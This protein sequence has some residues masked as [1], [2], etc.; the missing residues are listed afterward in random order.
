MAGRPVKE[1]P[2]DDSRATYASKIQKKDAL[3][4]WTPPA[5]EISC[6]IRALDPSPGAYTLL[7]GEKLKLFS[8]TV[9]EEN[10]TNDVPGRILRCKED[11]IHV[12][13]GQGIVGIR[14]IQYPGKKRL[15]VSDFLRGFSLSE[16]T[17][18][19]K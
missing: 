14:E 4:D 15:P 16:G 12:Q 9:V 6:L 11:E 7:N 3:V 8:S 10:G 1:T 5:F 19:G 17:V 18:L 13:S 2:Q